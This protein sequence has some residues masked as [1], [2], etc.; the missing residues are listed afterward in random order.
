DAATPAPAAA[1]FV[2]VVPP[3]P[4]LR[5]IAVDGAG[6]PGPDVGG[7]PTRVGQVLR[8]GTASG[9]QRF[10]AVLADGLAPVTE[11]AADLILGDPANRA[12]YPSAPAPVNTSPSAVAHADR[13]ARD[14]APGYPDRLPVLLDLAGGAVCAAGAGLSAA[15]LSVVAAGLPLPA[16]AGAPTATAQTDPRLADRVYVPPGT[17]AL[18]ATTQSPGA[19]PGPVYLVTDAGLKF[20]VIGADAV[21]ALG[22]GAVRAMPV[23]APVLAL[24]P[25]G[26]PLDPSAAQQVVGAGR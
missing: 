7:R 12:A 20:P 15:S 26:V 23:A 18:V 11:P 3:G 9:T 10:Y 16:G 14:A 17:G 2:G 5:A 25:S 21:R 4:D 6:R 19:P 24:L 13:S 22:Y 8:V 1:A